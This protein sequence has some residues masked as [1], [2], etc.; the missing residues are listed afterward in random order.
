MSYDSEE[1]YLTVSEVSAL[2]RLSVLTIYKYIKEGKIEAIE[3]GGHYRI[4]HTS[5][6]AFIENHRVEN[7]F[8][9]TDNTSD[10]K[11]KE[12]HETQ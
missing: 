11:N 5:L 2:L 1:S 9:S 8:D 6:K 10:T 4:S 3:F 7:S 12:E